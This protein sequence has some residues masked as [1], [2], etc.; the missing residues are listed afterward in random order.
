MLRLHR[1]RRVV[2]RVVGAARTLIEIYCTKTTAG[3]GSGN[4]TFTL[5]IDGSPTA[6][7][8]AMAIATKNDKV[9]GLSVAVPAGSRV[10]V[11]HRQTGQVTTGSVNPRVTLV[12]G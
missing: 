11:A 12:W 6:G 5:E 8:L 7:V 10:A 3:I 4:E 1:H 2:A 9:T